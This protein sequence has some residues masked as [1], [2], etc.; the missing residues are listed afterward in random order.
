MWSGSNFQKQLEESTGPHSCDSCEYRQRPINLDHR[1]IVEP[2]EAGADS[3]TQYAHD[4]VDL[5]LRGLLETI[6]RRGFHGESEYGRFPQFR[7]DETQHH[8]GMGRVEQ[9]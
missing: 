2:A 3:L 9:V 7:G 1:R 8:R 5:Y 4:L 6:C